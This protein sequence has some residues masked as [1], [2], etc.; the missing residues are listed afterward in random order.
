M[1]LID[2]DALEAKFIEL[3]HVVASND[4][5]AIAAYIVNKFPTIDPVHAAGGQYCRECK[6]WDYGKC[7]A[8]K[9]GLIRDYT[10]PNDFCSYG[11]L[12]EAQDA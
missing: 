6:Y 4:A 1:R 12:E 11:E 10:I 7:E 8:V 2:A 5:A 3:G 9:N